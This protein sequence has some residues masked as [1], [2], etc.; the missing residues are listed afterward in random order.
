MKPDHDGVPVLITE[1]ARS[2]EEEL[3]TRKRRY[4]TVMLV[5]IPCLAVA[6]TAIEAR[7]HPVI[8]G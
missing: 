2:H 4:L 7:D 5:R 3:A 1:A 6:G 8:D